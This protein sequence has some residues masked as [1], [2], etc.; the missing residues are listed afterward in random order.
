MTHLPIPAYTV[1]VSNGGLVSQKLGTHPVVCCPPAVVDNGHSIDYRVGC[2]DQSNIGLEG[3]N[4]EVW[5]TCSVQEECI[6]KEAC[7]LF[8]IVKELSE[9]KPNLFEVL[10]GYLRADCAESGTCCPRGPKSALDTGKCSPGSVCTYKWNC[11]EYVE[12]RAM[13]ES[14]EVSKE[15]RERLIKENK[16]KICDA[17]QNTIC[18]SSSE[19]ANIYSLYISEDIDYS[20]PRVKRSEYEKERPDDTPTF[21]EHFETKESKFQDE[22]SQTGH[23]CIEFS[24]CEDLFIDNPDPNANVCGWNTER[25]EVKVCCRTQRDIKTTFVYPIVPGYDCED[26]TEMCKVWAENGAC[27]TG[28]KGFVFMEQVLKP[29]FHQIPSYP[30]LVRNIFTNIEMWDFMMSACPKS[31]GFCGNKGCRNEHE[32]C[33]IWAKHGYC[34]TNPFFMVHTCRESCGV[35]GFFSSENQQSQTVHT[36]DIKD[37]SNFGNQNFDC[38]RFESIDHKRFKRGSDGKF[39]SHLF[40]EGSLF[41]FSKETTQSISL[42]N[43]TDYYCSTTLISDKIA[44]SAAHCFDEFDA[45]FRMKSRY[46]KTIQFNSENPELIEIIQIYKHPRYKYPQFYDDIAILK[47]GRRVQFD[48]ENIGVTPLCLKREPVESGQ[49][50]KI[51]GRGLTETGERGSLLESE[52]RIIHNGECKSILKYNATDN[53]IVHQKINRALPLGLDYGLICGVGLQNEEGVFSGPCKGDSGAPLYIDENGIKKLIGIAS[54][55]IGCG[56][57]YPYWFTN[58]SQQLSWIDCMSAAIGDNKQLEVIQELC[59]KSFEKPSI[60]SDDLLFTEL[61]SR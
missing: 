28:G 33:S 6:I 55:G 37:Y 5:F 2:N 46:I 8:K 26:K 44:I 59:Q 9:E 50:A 15:Q 7:P 54:G 43:I 61:Q 16:E 42:S 51:L 39:Q 31:C 29:I 11:K 32:S 19:A 13:I 57:G 40:S 10:Q 49:L 35:C 21:S 34:I 1:A 23:N 52:V 4:P 27:N 36:Q 17:K 58:I 14:M 25:K 18:C 56:K 41:S 22:C 3:A 60:L 20:H 47:L 12:A 24:R 38:G 30:Q 53:V 48:F 45:S